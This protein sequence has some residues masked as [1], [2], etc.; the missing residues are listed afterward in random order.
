MNTPK[1]GAEV[2]GEGTSFGDVLRVGSI[3][4]IALAGVAYA[5]HHFYQ[6]PYTVPVAIICAV[7]AV[8]LL[9]L[10]IRV[11]R[12]EQAKARLV[13]F[14]RT[15]LGNTW[16]ADVRLSKWA[17]GLPQRVDLRYPPQ[18]P[19][20][21][22]QWQA[23]ITRAVEGRLGV[24]RVTAKWDIRKNRVIMQASVLDPTERARLS[25]EQR[26][27]D[28][29]SPLFRSTEV[30]VKV[31]EWSET[32][33]P[34]RIA[35]S[36]GA[37]TSD[38][39]EF[40]RRRVEATTGL[41]LGGR[42]RATF[43]PTA[44]TGELIPRPPMP[45]LVRH[46][47]VSVYPDLSPD[48]P[49]LFYGDDENGEHRGWKV[50]KSTTMPHMLVIGPTGGGKTTLLRSLIVAAVAQNVYVFGCDPK[51]IELTPFTGFPGVYIASTPK[52]I[53]DMITAITTLMYER[54]E[55][56]KA[57]PRA[58]DDM[59]P[60]LFVLDELLI[61]RQVVKRHHREHGGKD[62]GP[63][64]GAP[65]ALEQI[66]E[67]AALARSAKINLVIGVQRPD[68]SL[69]D[70]GAR[71]NFRQR[72]SIMRLSPE[73]SKMLWGSPYVGV[74]LPLVQGRAV[75]SPDGDTPVELQTFW[76]ADP[77]SAEGDDR[78]VL[79]GFRER[80]ER[81]FA[82]QV[83]PIP[84]AAYETLPQ[85][86]PAPAPAPSAAPETESLEDDP[87]PTFTGVEM[88][89]TEVHADS[90][91]TGDM[92]LIDGEE[93]VEIT[94]V[95]EDPFDDDA[96]LVTYRTDGGEEGSIALSSADYVRRV[97]RVNA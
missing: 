15:E 58:A 11:M 65:P 67:L 79:E 39:S 44:D 59:R 90:L 26:I 76:V 28:F 45:S 3:G 91:S 25:V 21:D 18:A 14:L 73:G 43:D 40:W 52:D 17:K 2:A 64:K 68:A 74:D 54:Y 62:G 84:T 80:A 61:L 16:N 93:P 41:K 63:G 86:M 88:P 29:L 48:R 33:T 72:A 42:W 57:N 30:R 38:G 94:D 82:D 31:R 36:Y 89:V 8:P 81:L 56:I 35:L 10:T 4:L 50:G 75:A 5:A 71:D 53:A 34:Q 6:V 19:D 20:H 69:F 27:S 12:H 97:D 96:V 22:P 83:P 1:D 23:S 95:S 87:A 9:L 13:A 92:A 66:A 49:I 77:I 70:E 78:T 85:D 47:G 46:P 37:I 7:L 55:K 60:V 24:D 51:M 32:E